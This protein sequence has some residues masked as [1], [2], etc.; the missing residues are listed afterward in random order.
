VHESAPW[1]FTTIY[2]A[3]FD[4]VAVFV[5]RCGRRFLKKGNFVE[6][7]AGGYLDSLTN[8]GACCLLGGIEYRVFS[9][10]FQDGDDLGCTR[11]QIV[12][13]S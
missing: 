12:P 9:Y 13:E 3:S 7:L 5:V 4:S 8:V 10:L 1:N 6:Y 2:S 11:D